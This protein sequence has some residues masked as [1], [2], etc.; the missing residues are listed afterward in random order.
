MYIAEFPFGLLPAHS[1]EQLSSLNEGGIGGGHDRRHRGG[2]NGSTTDRQDLLPR[3]RNLHPGLCQ[4]GQHRRG[5]YAG[6]ARGE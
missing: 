4:P 5:G 6:P 3:E 2:C 1:T